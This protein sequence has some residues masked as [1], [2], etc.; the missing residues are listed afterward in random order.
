VNDKPKDVSPCDLLTTEYEQANEWWR[1]IS[2]MR[3]H[4]LAAFTA[5][6]GAV[7]TIV[8][9]RLVHRMD[10]RDV[11]LVVIAFIIAAIGFNNETR[12]YA[13]LTAF[14]TRAAEL[15]AAHGLKLL[16]QAHNSVEAKRYILSSSST[17]AAYYALIAFG[18]VAVLIYNIVT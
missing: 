15:E 14:R 6:E 1:G 5:L 10:I 7:V 12:L 8:G 9:D 16:T 17:F 13:Y 18:W 2:Q 4:D 11:L 3:R